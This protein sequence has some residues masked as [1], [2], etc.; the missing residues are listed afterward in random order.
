VKLAVVRRRYAQFGGAERFIDTAMAEIAKAGI[1][2]SIISES[3]PGTAGGA[4][5]RIAVSQRGLTRRGKL[6]NFQ[7]AVGEIVAEH[8]F[9]LV[10]THERLLSADIFRAGDGVHAAWLARQQAEQGGWL[11][12]LRRLDPMH[13]LLVETE[14]RM[15]RKSDMLFVANSAMIA[16]EIADWLGVPTGR[17]RIIE[18]GVDTGRFHPPSQVERAVARAQFTL[19]GDSPVVAFVGSGFDRK[20]AFQLIEA[21]ALPLCRD[22]H[23]LIAGRDRQ[24]KAL[25]RCAAALG[26]AD[27][28]QILGGI[29]DPLSVYHAADLFVLP[30]L[31]DPLPNAAL[32]ALACGLPLVVTVDTG[33]ADAVKD[34]GAGV[35]TTRAPDDIAAGIVTVLGKRD[36][37]AKGAEALK[38]RFDLSIATARWLAL[39]R[40]LA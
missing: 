30:S 12:W 18:N 4:V 10:Q 2:L 22:V 38:R 27:R 37:M 13:R 9:D 17:I 32:E 29:A 33:V 35:V 26:L 23:A 34:G 25:Q 14:R 39:Y 11:P 1:D 28:V 19:A 3:W 8:K 5:D 6:A 15:A 40:E 21:L 31:Y 36:D 16:R 7:R 20:G 24:L